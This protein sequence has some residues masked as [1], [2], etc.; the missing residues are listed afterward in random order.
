MV[1]EIFKRYQTLKVYIDSTVDIKS[2]IGSYVCSEKIGVFE[3]R[4]GPLIKAMTTGSIL[5]LENFQEANEEIIFS[6]I[7]ISEKR[8]LDISTQGVTIKAKNGFKIIALANSS[9]MIETKKTLIEKNIA[10]FS[11][12]LIGCNELIFL[13]KDKY[14]LMRN[15]LLSTYMEKSYKLLSELQNNKKYRDVDANNILRFMNFA[16]RV[17]YHA[18]RIYGET[19]VQSGILTEEFRK[20]ILM[21]LADTNLYQNKDLVYDNSFMDKVAGI[22]DLSKEEINFSI[23]N[24][25]PHIEITMDNLQIGKYPL[26][27]RNHF[28]GKTESNPTIEHQVIY[29]R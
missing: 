20:L 6:L 4:N 7:K 1:E 22:L 19:G 15:E 21:E 26:I 14:P 27:K 2:L 13:I 10:V 9:L 3:W 28:G 29:N 12:T 16:N 11:K 23:L 8:N 17:N 5:I 24:Y 25:E 18:S